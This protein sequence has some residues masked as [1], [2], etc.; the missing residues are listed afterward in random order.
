MRRS[1]GLLVGF[2]YGSICQEVTTSP[3]CFYQAFTIVSPRGT[4]NLLVYLP[5]HPALKASLPSNGG[6]AAAAA[7]GVL[8]Y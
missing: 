2:H 7:L 1:A 8:A 4:S 3:A 6:L 5:P